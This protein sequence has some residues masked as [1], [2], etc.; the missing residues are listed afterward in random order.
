MDVLFERCAGLDVHKQTVVACRLLNTGAGRR[1]SD[2][3]TF[4]T[5][6]AEILRLSDWLSAEGVTHV[7]MESTGVYWKPIFNLLEGSFTVWVLNA[8]HVKN[9]PGRKTDVK[10]AQWLADL[11]RHGLVRPS[12]IPPQEQRDLRE[13]TRERTNFV[14]QRATL[15]N[16]VQK[17]LEAANIKL[18]D[19]AADVLGVSG[20]A[21]LEALVAGEQ[22]PTV[23]AD[24][25]KGRLRAKR[26][27]LVA[28]LQG[29]LRP[30]QRFLLTELLGQITHLEATIA[31]FDEQIAAACVEQQAFSEAA[32]AIPGVGR[33]VI[34]VV[35][36]EIGPEVSR[37]PTAGHLA[38]WAGVAP[39]NNE[40]AGRQRS[41]RARAGN[42][43]LRAVLLQAA[44]G[45]AHSK[46]TYLAAQ[47]RRIAARRGRKRALVAVAHSLVVI[48]YHMLTR[49]EP[50]QDLGADYF[51]R[52][53]PEQ[54]A[55]RLVRQGAKLGYQVTLTPIPAAA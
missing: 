49:H 5:T 53:N 10:D 32:D 43:W 7:A 11:L 45:A 21:I 44:Q 14:R 55:R 9:V 50:Y 29:Q 26:A 51:E 41:G 13:L 37:F 6:T 31:R 25:A 16:R 4:G 2:I 47:Y 15:V 17:V 48:L 1:Q 18:G 54:L 24:L 33:V 8:Q 52:R 28:A 39:G 19:V 30:A 20:R 34:E 3:Q 46:D 27:A 36:A 12:F 35:L 23:L 38:A 42:P 40:S 22:D